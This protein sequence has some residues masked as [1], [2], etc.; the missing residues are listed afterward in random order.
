M[1]I[2]LSSSQKKLVLIIFLIFVLFFLY[3]QYFRPNP[4]FLDT[5][6][7]NTPEQRA[8]LI[9]FEIENDTVL[10]P[11]QCLA[12]KWDMSNTKGVYINGSGVAAPESA[13]FCHLSTMAGL[14]IN[15]RVV[16]PDETS[17][18][19]DFRVRVLIYDPI[20]LISCL[21]IIMT[22]ILLSGKKIETTRQFWAIFAGT[23][24]IGIIVTISILT[25]TINN[26]LD[27]RIDA[28]DDSLMFARYA[29][30]LDKTG[31]WSWNAGESPVFG[32][33][34]LAYGWVVYNNYV[35]NRSLTPV[36]LV[37]YTSA[38]IG[39]IW[40]LVSSVAFTG[41]LIFSKHKYR[42]I[43]II[44][45]FSI[46]VGLYTYT[47]LLV[48][49]TSGMG[50]T[51]A[52]LYITI[53]LIVAH[54]AHY[55]NILVQIALGIF[56]GLAFAVRPD[57]MLFTLCV[58]IAFLLFSKTPQA[59]RNAI[60]VIVITI[61]TLG[62][63]MLM[64]RAYFGSALPL[65]FFAKSGGIYDS[66]LENQY[67]V[68]GLNHFKEY[69]S[70]SWYFVILILAGF[71]G[72]NK[73]FLKRLGPVGIGLAVGA[74]GY[75][76]YYMLFVI[77]IMP[78]YQRF[79]YPTFPIIIWLA[80]IGSI[81]L[82]ERLWDILQLPLVWRFISHNIRLAS[83]LGIMIITTF[84]LYN[85][86]YTTHHFIASHKGTNY[87]PYA[88]WYKLEEFSVIDNITVATTEVGALSVA[89][90][91][92]RVIDLAGLNDVRF[93]LE[94]FSADILLDEYRPDL[95]YLPVPDYVE[96]IESIVT[97]P[98][99]ARDYTY[100]TAGQTR[101]SMGIAIRNDSPAYEQLMAIARP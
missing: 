56:G 87:R 75:I 91:S 20:F 4:Q 61:I 31:A 59:R 39:V 11:T 83:I 63:Q 57:L 67:L 65:P 88:P 3:T 16:L 23:S 54:L 97:H 49:F 79:Y 10:F 52:L 68:M 51:T 32:M 82:L 8:T 34:E 81:A 62:I 21:L 33:T 40:I 14:F 94:A 47:N 101:M 70:S 30:N 48:H 72:N 80:F 9:S 25:L 92:W 53:Y 44:A 43:V 86:L 15:L 27:F 73:A 17:V 36:Q 85:T 22:L 5:I 45:L 6:I 78:Q 28:W 19:Y 84:G 98:N 58:P 2:K 13:N 55:K 74:I 38:A 60:V 35:A 77:Q 37:Q 89:N 66:Y 1:S 42:P 29:Y 71:I 96:M 26:F 18:S 7:P 64:A 76:A 90:F 41:Y 100:F 69:L 95:L 12:T 99:F 46:L 24:V 50:T 93:S